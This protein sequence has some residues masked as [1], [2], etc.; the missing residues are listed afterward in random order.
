MG[1]NAGSLMSDGGYL[2]FIILCFLGIIV[3]SGDPDQYLVNILLLNAA[4]MIGILTYFTSVTTGLVLNIVFLLAYGTY[5]LYRTM[6]IGDTLSA[7]SYFWLLLTPLFTGAIWMMT[8]GMLRLQAEAQSLKEINGRLATMDRHTNLRNS[9]LFQKDATVFMALSVRYGIPLTLVVMQIRY[10]RDVRRMIG[11]SDITEALIQLSE[12]GETSIRSNDSLYMLD[13]ENATWGLL[14][15]TDGD[16]AR[17]VANR[18]KANLEQFNKREGDGGFRVEFQL[19]IG[20]YQYD[21]ETI[22]SPLEL[23]DMA[24]KQLEYDV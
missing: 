4:F 23:I 7:S 9:L 13:E 21:A 18:I 5:T 15:F 10:W 1:R 12:L 6:A 22:G 17:I 24:R 2:S 3:V 8:S 19:R 11:E 20:E 16:G 14:L